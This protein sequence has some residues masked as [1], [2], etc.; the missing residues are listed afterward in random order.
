MKKRLLLITG[1][2]PFGESERG[3]LSEEVKMLSSRFELPVM[4]LDSQDPL[5]Y[6]TDGI[7]HIERY[8]FSSFRKTG[9]LCALPSVFQWSTL[10]EAWNFAKAKKFSDPVTKLR[11]TLYYRFNVWEMQQQIGKLV[12]S[13]NV[14][15][16]YTY[17]CSECT[18]AAV[19][20]KK[21]FP[22]LKVVTRF[23]GVDLYEDRTPE[24]WQFFR[25]EIARGADGLC[26][27]CEYGRTYFQQ[28]WGTKYAEKMH[29][30]YLGST[31][32]GMISR[33]ATDKLCI[34]SCSNLIP[35]K[36]VDMIIEALA[37]LP[38]SMPIEWNHFGDGNAREMLE[39]LAEEKLRDHTNIKWKFRGFVPNTLL[40]EAYKK[41]KPDLFITASSTEGGAPVSIQEVFSMGIPAIGTPVGGIPDLI[42]DGKSGF[43]LPL[44]TAPSHMA[45][46]I[47]KYA[48]LP[49]AQKTQMAVTVR[50]LW[51]EKFDAKENALNYTEYL[52]KLIS[53]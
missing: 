26:F 44:Q 53:E 2:Y 11:R 46:A 24:N 31:D 32:R 39:A 36:R 13:K 38:D 1:G 18:V 15:I 51:Q 37:L 19:N 12:Q 29:V 4:A 50:Q 23:H 10:R 27:A 33:S 3:F 14:D 20:L 8:Q 35:L 42:A 41:V 34:V 28:C 7:V 25:R 17:W 49:D 22:H 52:R 9:K 47:M 43:L 5:V 30:F 40:T 21:R 6:P 16:V 45:D 48:A